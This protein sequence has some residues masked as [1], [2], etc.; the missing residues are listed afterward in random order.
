MR[1][2]SPITIT[3]AA[4]VATAVLTACSATPATS[5]DATSPGGPPFGHFLVIGISGDYN[6]RAQ[7]ER[8]LVG[9]LRRKGAQAR[10]Y[11]Q[12]IG[13]NQPISPDSV[14]TALGSEEFDAILVTRVLDSDVDVR[15]KKSREQTDATPIGGRIVNL[16][17]YDYTDYSNPGRIDLTT[18]ISFAIELYDAATEEIIWSMESSSRGEKNLGLLIDKTAETIAK[19]VSREK[20]IR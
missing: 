12:V 11:H 19:R 13:S 1:L 17:R 4:L 7:F 5:D 6:S 15:V 14:R 18:S 9:E 3:F 8:Q 16:F 10:A 2:S 20:F